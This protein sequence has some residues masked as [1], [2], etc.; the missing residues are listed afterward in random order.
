M[1]LGFMLTLVCNA[2]DCSGPEP[3]SFTAFGLFARVLESSKEFG[4]VHGG[5]E[6]LELADSMCVLNILPN[7]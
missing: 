6:G 2:S 4:Y 1:M 3:N 5:A 7:P